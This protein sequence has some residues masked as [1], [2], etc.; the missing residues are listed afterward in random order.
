MG[1]GQVI[2]SRL[3]G[4]SKGVSVVSSDGFISNTGGEGGNFSFEGFDLRVELVNFRFDVI[5][6]VI[7]LMSP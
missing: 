5:K 6:S 1:A 2:Q 4:I 3:G 7:L